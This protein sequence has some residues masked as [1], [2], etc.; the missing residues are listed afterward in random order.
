LWFNTQLSLQESPLIG[1][2]FEK[3]TY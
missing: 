3:N 1:G 2:L